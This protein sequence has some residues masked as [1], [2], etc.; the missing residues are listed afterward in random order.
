[1]C[2][3][4]TDSAGCSALDVSLN[5]KEENHL[6]YYKLIRDACQGK[7]HENRNCTKYIARMTG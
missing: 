1:M 7:E 6:L 5:A 4:L 3:M 2:V